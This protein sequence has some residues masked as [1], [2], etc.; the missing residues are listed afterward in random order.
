MEV[1]NRPVSFVPAKAGDVYT[2]GTMKLRVM[3][4][5]SNTGKQGLIIKTSS[6]R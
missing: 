2:L 3:E 5:G 6:T 4:D 1:P